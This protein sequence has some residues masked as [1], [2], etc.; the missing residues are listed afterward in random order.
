MSGRLCSKGFKRRL[1]YGF[2]VKINF[3]LQAKLCILS[4]KSFITKDK[5]G[6][7]YVSMQNIKFVVMYVLPYVP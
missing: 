2:V 1:S 5:P 4:L 7:N 3:W 6:L